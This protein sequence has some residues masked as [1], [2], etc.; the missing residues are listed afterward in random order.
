MSEIHRAER[1]LA[2]TAHAVAVAYNAVW[3][4]DPQRHG[5]SQQ[6]A[7]R[8]RNYAWTNGWAPPAA[9]DDDTL[10]DPDAIPDWTGFCG[11]DRG[12]WTHRIEHIPVCPACEQAHTDWL[13]A[14]KHLPRRE[15]AVLVGRAQAQAHNRGAAIAEN[16][17]ELLALGE[18]Y[19]TAA[20][21]IGVSRNHLQQELL[22]H[23]EQQLDTAA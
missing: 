11:T 19:E 22:R 4:E 18:T 16:A 1:L 8:F 23:P 10:D 15:R 21:R 14:I 13:A 17:R 9:W 7:C 20:A 3:N 12:W 6:A 2:T 5:V